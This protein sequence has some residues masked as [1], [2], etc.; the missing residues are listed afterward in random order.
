ME[1]RGDEASVMVFQVHQREIR[2]KLYGCVPAMEREEPKD[3]DKC[4]CKITVK[5][6]Q[7][8][9]KAK[10]I[11]AVAIDD[12]RENIRH[13]ICKDHTKGR[14]SN[15]RMVTITQKG[16]EEINNTVSLGKNSETEAGDHTIRTKL[17]ED[18]QI[19]WHK[20]RLLQMSERERLPKLKEDS[21]L[22]KL[23]D[24]ING[25]IEELLEENE[26]DITEINNLINAA[27]TL[28][29]AALNQHSKRGKNRRDENFWK[30]RIQRQIS[31]WRKEISIIA[32]LGTGSDNSKLNR[33]KRKI[34]QKYKVTNARE[35]AQLIETLKQKVQAKAQRTRRYEKRAAHYI[36]NKM[37]KEDTKKFHRNWGMNIE[38]KGPPSMAEVEPY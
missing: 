9:L 34:F 14:D 26:S 36:Q 25:I 23:K 33:K 11:S 5:P 22:I 27:A 20:V 4:R 16:E 21:K 18:L 8:Y 3:K 19:M 2:G 6:K 30:I 29:T 7:L 24:E 13:E 28:V 31:N 1:P 38:A 12:I 17:K 32:E 35:V 10:R 37:F 15:N